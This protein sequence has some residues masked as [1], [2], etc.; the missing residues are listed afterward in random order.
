MSTSGQKEKKE[1]KIVFFIMWF[2][3]EYKTT[4][5]KKYL[6]FN[7]NVIRVKQ[8]VFHTCFRDNN[9]IGS[10]CKATFIEAMKI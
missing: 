4:F 3:L 10:F 5:R 6:F 8:S 9:R 2:D 7:L 1:Q